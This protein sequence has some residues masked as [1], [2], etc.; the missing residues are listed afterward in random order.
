MELVTLPQQPVKPV[1]EFIAEDLLAGLNSELARRIDYHKDGFAKFWDN[2]V[3]PDEIAENIGDYG[4]LFIDSANENLRSI[5]NLA[6]LVGK[7]LN[8]AIS[9]EF[10][11]PR[12]AI[13]FDGTKIVL[14][15]PTEG[16]NAWGKPV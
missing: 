8:D 4:K 9:P 3:T 2:E 1:A 15:V 14:A 12:R 10:Y 7:T 6:A 11:E 16:F 13:S 5:E